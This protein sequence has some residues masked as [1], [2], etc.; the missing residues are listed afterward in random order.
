[1]PGENMPPGVNPSDI[2]GNRPEDAAWEEVLEDFYASLNEKDQ[3]MLD[4]HQ[5]VWEIISQAIQYGINLGRKE[6]I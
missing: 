2:P 4:T 1:M 3:A 6:T 5:Y